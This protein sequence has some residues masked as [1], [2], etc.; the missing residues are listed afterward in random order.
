M[1]T[2]LSILTRDEVSE[3]SD[4]SMH[5]L[6]DAGLKVESDEALDL[7]AKA[8]AKIDTKSNIVKIPAEVVE[9][10]IGT[11][12]KRLTL[13]SR[14]GKRDVKLY[15]RERPAL[16]TDGIGV[17]MLDYRTNAHRRS[18]S[19]DLYRLAL[20]SDFLKEVDVFWP[21]VVAGDVPESEHTVKEFAISML[22]TSKHVQHEAYGKLEARSEI[23]IAQTISGGKEGLRRRP[24]FSAVQCPVS[25]LKLEVEASEAAIEFS[26][27]GVPVV[28]M[29][30][31]QMGATAPATIPATLLLSNAE[32]LGALVLSQ[33]ASKGAPFIYGISSG[34][35][36]IRGTGGFLAGS[37]ELS[38]ISAAGAQIARSYGL[39]SLVAG[40]TTDAR[41][42]SQQ[43]SFEK[44]QTCMLPSIAGATIVSGI[45]GLDSGN[46]IS[47]EQMVIDADIWSG[48]L[49]AIGGI[50]IERK[51]MHLDIIEKN[52]SNANYDEDIDAL[53]SY[54]RE[55]WLPRLPIRQSYQ[56]WKASGGKTV[57]EMAA[58]VV[59]NAL[60]SHRV[61][62]L[63]KDV[64]RDIMVAYKKYQKELQ[65]E[66]L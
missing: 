1:K 23:A 58:E 38:L 8:G 25:P 3:V 5:I 15:D 45:G 22:G 52:G 21:M 41:Y 33:A 44:L 49:R 42:H 56:S 6:S 26:R 13:F 65:G 36:D 2:Q 18:T 30:I 12:P 46:M 29:S 19:R 62:A 54:N 24:I 59:K 7:L 35:V 43:A 34:P 61:R 28:G 37:P 32:T 55:V 16:S 50:E 17:K 51:K 20:L 10:A 60:E 63:D 64:E 14:D 11:A 53:K 57:E 27:A 48:M 9:E 47:M 39:P 66:R 40:M 4:A 31:A